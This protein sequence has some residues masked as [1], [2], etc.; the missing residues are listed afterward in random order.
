MQTPVEIADAVE[1]WARQQGRHGRLFWQPVMKCFCIEFTLKPDDPRRKAWQEQTVKLEKEPTES[2]PLNTWDPEK[3]RH[4]AW[5]LEQIGVEGIVQYL[6]KA[7]MM[8]GRGEHKDM[9][10]ALQA[11]EQRNKAA[12][13]NQHDSIGELGR[14]IGWLTY[15][16][17]K[18]N[19]VVSV[20]DTIETG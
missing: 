9:W 3:K 5:N 15:N 17:F 18:G 10:A 12:K 4:R 6:D 11:V 14:E 19:P 13:K 1:L 20:P 8:S 16:K 2:V 7:N